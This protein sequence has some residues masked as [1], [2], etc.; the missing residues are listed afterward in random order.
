MGMHGMQK[1]AVLSAALF[2]AGAAL[3]DK[4]QHG[5]ITEPEV[6]AS[7]DAKI[8]RIGY[9]THAVENGGVLYV[10]GEDGVAAISPEGKPQWAARLPHADVRLISADGNGIA[11]VAQSVTGAEP[12]AMGRFIKGDLAEVPDFAGATVGLLD[13][14]RRGAVLWTTQLETEYRVAPPGISGATV[15]I[16]DGV[17]LA[18]FDRVT[19]AQ[20]SRAKTFPGFLA[21][22]WIFKGATRN[23]PVYANDSY[24][25]AF[26]SEL[27]RVDAATG[28]ENWRKSNHGLMS[29]FN[30]ITAGPVLWGDKIAFGN[31][32]NSRGGGINNITRIFVGDTDGEQVW[33]DRHDQDSGIASLAVRG[34][35]LYAASNFRLSAYEID[36]KKVKELWSHDTATTDGALTFSQLRGVRFYQ[37]SKGAQIAEAALLA[38]L[39]GSDSDDIATRIAYGNC[40]VADDRRVYLSSSARGEYKIN[41][42]LL[43]LGNVD[44]QARNVGGAELITV[45][46]AGTGKLAASI[47]AKGL[48]FD[49]LLL[50]PNIAT[51]DAETIRIFRRPD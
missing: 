19:G 27:S 33:N 4:L 48:I 25:V 20:V 28:K 40:L 35:R 36:G 29:P 3:A 31:S 13:K 49:L 1:W 14:G 34:D 46:D 32:I 47:D 30:N 8:L 43:M 23:A 17:T 51:Y 41:K 39:G 21:G 16:S 15:A 2:A 38:I 45:V 12:G 44:R 18:L 9:L 5:P 50:G 26:T 37:R 10:A 24:Y 11:Y 22:H 42:A 6:V 7:V